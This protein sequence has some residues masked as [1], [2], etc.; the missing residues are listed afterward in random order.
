LSGIKAFSF[1]AS[2]ST[3][4]KK[5]NPY[6]MSR[7]TTFISPRTEFANFVKKEIFSTRPPNTTPSNPIF[8]KGYLLLISGLVWACGFSR[9][10]QP[11][12]SPKIFLG[13]NQWGKNLP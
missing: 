2:L 6:F 1:A 13:S 7:T 8:K 12:F 9:D 11:G 5:K 4:F 10:R 3:A